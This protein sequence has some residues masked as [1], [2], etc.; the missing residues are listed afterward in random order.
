MAATD[1]CCGCEYSR[2]AAVSDERF[3]LVEPVLATMLLIASPC[4]HL[5]PFSLGANAAREPHSPLSDRG[6][7]IRGGE[8]M[9]ITLFSLGEPQVLHPLL[10]V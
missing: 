2:P 8:M 5:S 10:N 3:F 6:K 1:W 9:L 7:A 4:L